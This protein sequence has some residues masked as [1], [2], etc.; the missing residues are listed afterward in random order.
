MNSSRPENVSSIFSIKG[1]CEWED[2][3]VKSS[4]FPDGYSSY[5]SCTITILQ[6][7]DLEPDVIFEVESCCDILEIGG[8]RILSF[9]DI[10]DFLRTGQ[11]IQW[12]TDG[13]RN[14]AGWQI[15]FEVSK[16]LIIA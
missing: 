12:D 10:P 11:I 7:V 16:F 15:C 6:H 9:D 1:D 13:A 14:R 3:C 2:A 8:T 4:N 5:D